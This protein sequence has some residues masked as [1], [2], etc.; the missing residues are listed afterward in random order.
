MQVVCG[1]AHTLVLTDEGALYAWGANSYG[2]LGTG[3]K[4][5]S[6]SPAR[7]AIEIGR[8]VDIAALHYSHISAAL[9]QDDE[10]YM[11]GQCRGQSVQDATR[12]PFKTLHDVFACYASPTVTYQPILTEVAK[13]QSLVQAFSSAFDDPSVSDLQFLVEGKTI[14]VHKA[15]LKIRCEYFRVMFQVRFLS[16]SEHV[17]FVS[18]N[19]YFYRRITGQRRTRKWLKSSSLAIRFIMLS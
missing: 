4:A 6:C 5:N 7:A 18:V 14:H 11:W 3:H 8:V 16:K 13:G 1:Y 2:Q 10:V 9:T 17:A 19:V 12:T 15:V